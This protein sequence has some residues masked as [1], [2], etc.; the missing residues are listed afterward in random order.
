MS[1]RMGTRRPGANARHARL[2]LADVRRGKQISDIGCVGE[3][4]GD[5]H[6][7]V[8]AEAAV[9]AHCPVGWQLLIVQSCDGNGPEVEFEIGEGARL[10]AAAAGAVGEGVGADIVGA[11]GWVVLAVATDGV[12]AAVEEGVGADVI[13][14]FSPIPVWLVA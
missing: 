3:F 4:L 7:E 14:G 11:C 1:S 10:N 8:A 2:E 9:V 5:G 6:I 12:G 13:E